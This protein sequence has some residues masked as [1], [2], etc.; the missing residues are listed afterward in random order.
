MLT[1]VEIDANSGPGMR[2]GKARSRS[3][4]NQSYVNAVTIPASKPRM[5]E[6]RMKVEPPVYLIG[7]TEL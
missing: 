5:R 1:L 3:Q 4:T 7:E 6:V 2:R